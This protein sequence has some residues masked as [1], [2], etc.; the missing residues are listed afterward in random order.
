MAVRRV[1]F[2][3]RKAI[4]MVA[5]VGALLGV[6][7]CVLIDNTPRDVVFSVISSVVDGQGTVYASG[8]TESRF[9]RLNIGMTARQVEDLL[10]PPL[11]QGEWLSSR[12]IMEP[13][14]SYTLPYRH[15]GDYWI[16][17]V[18]FCNGFVDHTDKHFYLD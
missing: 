4:A 11:A 7:R 1:Q 3:L 6:V 5:I 18:Y 17:R 8:Y 9:R 2:S 15:L 14:W 12:G 13:H 10:G 16:R